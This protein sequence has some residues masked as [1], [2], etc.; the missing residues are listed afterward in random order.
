VKKDDHIF[1]AVH[2]KNIPEVTMHEFKSHLAQYLNQL[3]L[4]NIDGIVIKKYHRRIA[5]VWDYNP[6]REPYPRKLI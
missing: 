4:G 1:H 6:G 3:R 2:Q 5:L